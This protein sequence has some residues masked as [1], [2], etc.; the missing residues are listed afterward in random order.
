[1]KPI[2]QQLYETIQSELMMNVFVAL[3]FYRTESQELRPHRSSIHLDR[4]SRSL[5]GI[6]NCLG[7]GKPRRSLHK[8]G[9]RHHV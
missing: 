7:S 5:G 6:V 1:M 4:R 8:P 3:R 2:V 9:A